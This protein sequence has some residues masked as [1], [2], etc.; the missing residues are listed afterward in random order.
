MITRAMKLQMEA[1]RT[2]LLMLLF[3]ISLSSKAGGKAAQPEY[4]LMGRLVAIN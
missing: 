1:R 2:E 3:V 4:K